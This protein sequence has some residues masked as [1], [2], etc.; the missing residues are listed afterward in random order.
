LKFIAFAA[1]SL[2]AAA[3][4]L[5][6]AA[7]VVPLLCLLTLLLAAGCWLLLLYLPMGF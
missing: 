6:V 2:Q 4:A 3:S 7:P 5:A 1:R